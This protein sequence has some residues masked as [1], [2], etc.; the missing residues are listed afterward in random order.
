MSLLKK[1]D[2]KFEEVVMG[3]LLVGISC[4]ILLQIVM[5]LLKMSLP[6]PEELARYFYVWLVF[7]SLAYTIRNRTN[8]RVDL[9]VNAFPA[10]LRRFMEVALQLI[11]AAFLGTL[12]YHSFR[13]I[14]AVKMSSQTS[15]ALEIPMYLIYLIV[16]AGFLLGALRALQQARLFMKGDDALPDKTSTEII[17]E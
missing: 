11:N 10:K 15:P 17:E 2:E 5:R 16:P 14:S 8:L 9:L 7:L 12:F 3:V 6:W 4:I 13:V 1:I